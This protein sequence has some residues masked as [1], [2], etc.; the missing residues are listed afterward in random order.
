MRISKII[1]KQNEEIEPGRISILVG[2]NNVG[3]SQTLIDIKDRM[4]NGLASKPVVI[5][6][7]HFVKP[8]IFD[9]LFE[10]ITLKDHPSSIGIKMASGINSHLTGGENININLE[11]FQNEFDNKDNLDFL[12]GS[13]SK[14]RLS[15]LDADSRLSL[16]KTVNSINPHEDIPQHILH[17]L[18]QDELTEKELAKAFRKAFQMAIKFDDSGYKDFC[19]RVAKQFRN[20]PE[21]TRDAF[22]IMSKYNKL[23]NQG[24]GFKSFVGIVLSILFSKDRIVLLDEPE[25]FLHPAQAKYLGKWIADQSDN[26]SGQLIISTHNSNFLSGVL[27]SN[28]SVNIYRVNREDDQTNYHLLPPSA[29]ESLTKSPMLSSQRV[30]EAIFQKGVVVCEADADRTIYQTV[31]QRVFDNQ[32]IL[33]VHSHNKQTLKDVVKLLVDAKIPVGAIADIDLLN[34]ENNFRNIVEALT[35]RPI[36]AALLQTRQDIDNSV[37]NQS[38]TEILQTIE[39]STAEF[40]Q[41]LRGQEHTLNGARG[42]LNRLRKE[43][44]KWA[45]QKELGVTGFDGNEQSKVRRFLGNLKSKKLFVVPVGELEK[46]M[47]L[48]TTQKNKWIVLALDELY[49]DNIPDNLKSFIK[50]ILTRM[51]E[52]VS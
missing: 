44:T 28:K 24:D 39:N 51:G 43:A 40:L 29:I 35:D 9:H 21:R 19:L 12:L 16:A 17:K 13:I 18:L 23:D 46:W 1:T 22:P 45:R 2:A 14:L 31:A 30:L 5:K 47:S 20:I 34:D 41:Q 27:S 15:F 11:H 50:D 32:N 25:A 48:E 26:F 33:F 10:G 38:D 36:S 52:N 4:I 37:Q 42:A 7:I 3:K 49:K 8:D 6:A